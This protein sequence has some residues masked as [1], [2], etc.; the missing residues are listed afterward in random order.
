MYYISENNFSRFLQ[1]CDDDYDVFL[2]VKKGN[3]RFFTRY[4]QQIQQPVVGEVRTSDPLKAFFF[5]AREK[6]ARDFEDGMPAES[7]KPA[8]IVG[9]KACDLAGFKVQDSVFINNDYLDPFYKNER[10]N[11]LII[12]S[13]CT[14]AI[15]TCFCLALGI[16]PYPI[17][18]FDI[19]LTPLENGYLV[20]VGSEA[21]IKIVEIHSQ[22]FTEPNESQKNE[23]DT[24]REHT[25]DAVEKNIRNYTIPLKDKF[26]GIIEK[27]Y[28]SDIWQDEA[29]TCVEC[30]A[31]NAICPT[32]HCFLLYDQ[33]DEKKMERLRIWDSCMIKDFAR[34]AGGANPREKLWMRLRNRFEKKFDFFPKIAD[35][36]ACTGCGRC[37]S[38]CPAKIDIRNVLKRLVH[39][40]YK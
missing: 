18:N 4:T 13:D 19:N 21:G 15:D 31:C 3:N 27:N 17:E 12:S 5:R 33:K 1:I 8:C 7:R 32:C 9:V 35:I 6:V 28:E 22:L 14:C 38:A 2:P 29:S 10:E 26:E 25:K 30:G 34:V 20:E 23:R 39:N 24:I 11:N 40:V 37:V 16:K 36:Y